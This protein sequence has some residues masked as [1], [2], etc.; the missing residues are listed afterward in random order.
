MHLPRLYPILDTASLEAHRFP[1]ERA[2]ALWLEGGARLLQLR[3][4]APWSRTMYGTAR[5]IARL[6]RDAGALL[7]VNDRADIA[8]LLEAGLHVGQDD[9][10]PADARRLL[11]PDA[12]IGFSSHNP[13]QVRAAAAEPV[14]YVAFGP[15]YPTTS[16]RNP[17]PVTGIE[18]LKECRALVDKPL[19]AIG[20]ITR[21]TAPAVLAAGADAVA[22]IRD[23]LPSDLSSQSLRSRMEEW[24]QL[25]AG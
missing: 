2:A 13:G 25:L 10:A 23:L 1:C 19:V 8:L 22:V 6:C 3:H 14:S 9:L 11:G 15:L 20:G 21:Q 16:K 18:R 5:E 7:I 24:Q 17:D 4:K 12:V